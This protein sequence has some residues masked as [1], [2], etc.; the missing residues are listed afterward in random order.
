MAA[1]ALEARGIPASVAE[2]VPYSAQRESELSVL[3]DDL[4]EAVDILRKTPAGNFVID[5][6]Q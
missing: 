6:P 2:R 4:R 3:A 1:S 5:Y